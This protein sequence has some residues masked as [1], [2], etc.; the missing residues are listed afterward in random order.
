LSEDLHRRAL[1]LAY[2]TVAYNVG[3]GVASILVGLLARSIA[4]IGFGLDSFVESLSSAVLI[5]R[6]KQHGRVSHRDEDRI[7]AK[8]VRLI[9][10]TFL[11]LAAYVAYESAGRLLG[12]ERALPSLLGIIIAAVSILLM[13]PLFYLKRTTGL[14][15]GS[16][17]V[18]ADSKETLACVL[19]SC[20]LLVGLGMNQLWG[21]WWADPA[22]ALGIAAWL[23]REGWETLRSDAD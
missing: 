12:R 21:L 16:R 17:S 8:A 7:E 18:I 6:L 5:W 13:V 20:V 10:V 23:V 3:E 15:M 22:A 14:R 9:G 11:L 2:V 19:L 1:L 4:L